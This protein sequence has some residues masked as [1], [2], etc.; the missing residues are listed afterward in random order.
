MSGVEFF[1]WSKTPR[2]FRDI[3]ITEKIDGTN[4]AVVIDQQSFGASV[5]FN[6][7]NLIAVV[8]DDSLDGVDHTGYPQFEYHVYAQSRKRLIHPGQDNAGFAQWVSMNAP[9]LVRD[10]GPGRHFGE[11]WGQGIQRKYGMPHKVFSL[12]NV[13]KWEPVAAGRGFETPNLDVV[14]VLYRGPHDYD[15]IGTTLSI[16]DKF[17]SVAPAPYGVEFDGEAEGII[18]YHTASNQV[19]KVTLR[20]DESPK[21]L[22]A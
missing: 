6:D 21:S 4:A 10:L 15:A 9:T 7:P 14:P 8:I 19:Y 1:A 18:I 16:L 22:V 2:Y 17:G 20:D 11:W 13:S 5:D 12:F 3:V